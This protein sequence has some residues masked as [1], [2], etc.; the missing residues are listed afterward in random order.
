[1][2]LADPGTDQVLEAA[3]LA[4]PEALALLAHWRRRGLRRVVL[5][6]GTGSRPWPA[7]LRRQGLEAVIAPEHGSTLAARTRYWEL[8]LTPSWRRWLPRGL[9]LP[10]R[11]IDDVVAQLLLERWLGRQLRRRSEAVLR[12]WPNPPGSRTGPAP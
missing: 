2:V 5:G 11:D 6:D 12:Q 7:E 8:R 4:P 9:R 1:M 3:I 10:P